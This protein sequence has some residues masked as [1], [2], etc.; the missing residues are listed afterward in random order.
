M[1]KQEK[2]EMIKKAITAIAQEP[3]LDPQAKKRGM[4]TLKE[5]YLRYPQSVN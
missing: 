3:K 4:K 5:A 2:L 1:T